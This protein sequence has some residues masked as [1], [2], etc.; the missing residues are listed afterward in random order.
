MLSRAL[1]YVCS[2]VLGL[3]S[4][5]GSVAFGADEKPASD[6]V[7][8]AVE[9]SPTGSLPKFDGWVN[10]LAYSPDSRWMAVG[11]KDQVQVFDATTQTRRGQFAG[12]FGKVTSLAFSPD[13]RQLAVGGYQTLQ[14]WSPESLE[15]TAE[16]KGHRGAVLATAFSPDGRTLLSVS[17]DESARLWNLAEGAS[18]SLAGH[19]YP[20]NGA[21]WSA[22][23]ARCVTVAGDELRPTKAGE[24]ILRDS[25]GA[26]LK[27]LTDHA[28]A[29]LCAAFSPDGKLMI[30]GGL[31]ERAIVY[32]LAADKIL[33][34][35]GEHQR[36]VNSVQ[37]V[38]GTDV[39]VSIGGGRAKGGHSVRAWTPRTGA[40][41]AIGEVHEAKILALAVSPDGRQ[42]ATGGQD[43]TVF[44]WDL[45]FLAKPDAPAAAAEPVPPAII[46][47]GVIGLDTSHA[48][49]FAKLLNDPKAE[50]DVAGCKVVAAYPKGS[51]DIKSSTE[52][53]PGY[54]KEFQDLGIEI[55]D[56]IPALLEKVDCVLLETNDGRPHLEQV[57]PVLTAGKR[58]FID[59]PIAGS[60]ADAVAI[61]EA[62]KQ[63]GVPVFSSS[64]LRYMAM[65]Q[66]IRSGKIGNVLGCD[67]YSPCSLEAT[68]PDFFWYGIHGVEILFTVMGTGCETVAR[69]Q[70][71]GFDFAV[72]TWKEGR[73]GTFRGIRQG[74]G[75]YGGVAFGDKGKVDLGAFGGYRPLA[76]EI[77]KFFKTGEV[78]VSPEE[79]LE[80]YAFMEAADESKRQG[81]APVKIADV[82]AHA[83]KAAGME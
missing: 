35:F 18:V 5:N 83:R 20:V 34:Y 32:D 15:K 3:A 62:S 38:P 47:V 56:S 23:G 11:L 77:V 26:P 40:E 53:V 17:D 61:F 67:A 28:R 37:F 19:S 66:E 46:R 33:G 36:P 81:G 51:P 68:H 24:V 80:I 74:A 69:T 78:P 1:P 49:A 50:P 25:G 45:A 29:A 55:V 58:C 22:D 64:S 42:V 43:Q 82:L 8:E 65:A 63:H 60:L 73:I 16:L 10:S 7:S 21:A 52:R 39:V 12:K 71:P 6:A 14:L 2:L 9:W 57:L 48:P 13:G 70:T 31:D 72:G 27:T 44:V 4:W 30:T 76:V 75:G 59:K 54:T 79:T 41:F